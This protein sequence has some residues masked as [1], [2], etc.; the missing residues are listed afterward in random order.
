MDAVDVVAASLI[1]TTTIRPAATQ[2]ECL[3]LHKDD[4]IDQRCV[5]DEHDRQLVIDHV[6]V[7]DETTALDNFLQESSRS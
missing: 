4:L 5:A 7:I 1:P 3:I 2:S 6:Y